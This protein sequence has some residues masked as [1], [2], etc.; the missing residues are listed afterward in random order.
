V[1]KVNTDIHFRC[2]ERVT[3]KIYREEFSLSDAESHFF[4]IQKA[5]LLAVCILT[6]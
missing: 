6:E 4:P 3:A 2:E 1:Y 5:I